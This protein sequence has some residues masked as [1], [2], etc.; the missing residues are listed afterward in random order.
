M[1]IALDESTH[2]YWDGKQKYDSVTDILKYLGLSRN[3]AGIS[4]FYAER[5]KAVHKAVELIDKGTLDESTVTETIRPYVAAYRK[6]L[7]ESEYKPHRWEIRLGHPLLRFA[8]TIDKVGY[9]PKLGLGIG[10]IKTT[11][12]TVDPSTEDQ[13]CAYEVLWNE[14][15]PDLPILWRYAIQLKSNGDY[16]LITRWSRTP[17]EDWLSIMTV[18]RKKQKRAF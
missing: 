18:Y 11:D 10:D 4:S 5:G 9:L 1:P 15:F 16:A 8:G 14:N 3:Y 12:G 2:T 6:F 17:L 13:L 7:R